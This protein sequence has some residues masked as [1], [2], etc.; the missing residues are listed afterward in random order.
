M[1]TPIDTN[2]PK[3]TVSKIVS[4]PVSVPAKSATV[5]KKERVPKK[6]AV[7]PVVAPVAAPA[8]V[9]SSSST[10]AI[11]KTKETKAKKAVAP[12]ETKAPK[13]KVSKAPKKETTE[14]EGGKNETKRAF[15]ITH[16]QRDGGKDASSVSGGR[17]MSKTPAGAARK[18]ANQACRTFGEDECT[19]QIHIRET[20]K[21]SSKKEYK[22]FATRS[23]VG[24]KGVDFKTKVG[25]KVKVPFK[26]SMQ[27]KSMKGAPVEEGTI[28]ETTN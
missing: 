23:L 19:I 3:K 14:Q 12:K 22:Y 1:S 6:V 25:E 17:F 11:K 24:E 20:S 5:P 21:N 10:P 15:T 18:A 2:K 4:K 9:A 16:V 26:Y 8:P 27:L 7:A 13:A 28:L